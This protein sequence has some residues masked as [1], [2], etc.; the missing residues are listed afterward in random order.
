MNFREKLSKSLSVAILLLPFNLVSWHPLSKVVSLWSHYF[1]LEGGQVV[2]YKGSKSI[3]THRYSLLIKQISS[4]HNVFFL[5]FLANNHNN[6]HFCHLSD[7]IL[8]H[9]CT[10]KVNQLFCL[11]QHITYKCIFVLLKWLHTQVIIILFFLSSNFHFWSYSISVTLSVEWC[12][13]IIVSSILF[14]LKNGF[15]W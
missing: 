13:Y 14:N 5:L 8:L 15:L 3:H 6:I 1:V 4:F 2:S 7:S 9:F 12:F 11:L 10:K